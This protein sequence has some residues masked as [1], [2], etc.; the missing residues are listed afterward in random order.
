MRP[1]HRQVAHRKQAP[2]AAVAVVAQVQAAQPRPR[3]RELL[4]ARRA[5]RRRRVCERDVL[6]PAH[7]EQRPQARL[8]HVVHRPVLHVRVEDV[9]PQRHRLQRL[10]ARE[11]RR[12]VVDVL[13]RRLIL[14]LPWLLAGFAT[15]TVKLDRHRD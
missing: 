4:E 12:D 11:R 7:R 14:W 2:V 3:A 15:E 13:R 5:E 1:K 8:A 10:D 9:P 6:Q